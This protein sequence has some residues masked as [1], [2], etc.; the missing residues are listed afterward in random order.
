MCALDLMPN[1]SNYSAKLGEKAN[2][3]VTVSK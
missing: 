3:V 2:K 1:T